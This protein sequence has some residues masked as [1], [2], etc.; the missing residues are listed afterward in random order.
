M[1]TDPAL[2]KVSDQITIYPLIIR[3]S[4]QKAVNELS[5]YRRIVPGRVAH[6]AVSP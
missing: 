6:P 1:N 2:E 5:P 4:G 3:K